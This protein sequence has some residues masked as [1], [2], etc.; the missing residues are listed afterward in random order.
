MKIK[1][2]DVRTFEWPESTLSMEDAEQIR[3]DLEALN[4]MLF[5]GQISPAEYNLKSRELM[6]IIERNSLI[7]GTDFELFRDFLL[8]YYKDK[9]AALKTAEHELEHANYLREKG[10]GYSFRLKYFTNG[11]V[12]PYTHYIKEVNPAENREEN[13]RFHKE[14]VSAPDHDMSQ[15][16][17]DSANFWNSAINSF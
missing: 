17:H 9:E 14:F 13:I 6:L 2:F 8:A 11:K 7:F 4:L 3:K 15:S 10:I 16:D 12:Q 1:K 5:R